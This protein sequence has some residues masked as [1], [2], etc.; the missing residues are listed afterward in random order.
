M[1]CGVERAHDRRM[2]SAILLPLVPFTLAVS[3]LACGPSTS[4]EDVS[5]V[6]TTTGTTTGTTVAP[7]PHPHGVVDRP[8]GAC[9]LDGTVRP[10]C[11]G[12]VS[13]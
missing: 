11:A 12:D 2:R 4:A 7:T 10:P 8:C 1:R 6:G 3:V 5:V 9:L 13:R